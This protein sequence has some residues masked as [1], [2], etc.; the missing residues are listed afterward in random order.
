MV[1][2]DTHLNKLQLAWSGL[3]LVDTYLKKLELAW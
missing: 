3:V 1:H 2:G